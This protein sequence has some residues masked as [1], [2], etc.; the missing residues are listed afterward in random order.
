MSD[1]IMDLHFC[2]LPAPYSHYLGGVAA[3][4]HKDCER[5]YCRDCGKVWVFTFVNTGPAALGGPY[6]G[7]GYA[8][9]PERPRQRRERLG[10]EPWWIRWRPW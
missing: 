5:W 8:W 3:V 1:C 6:R 4:N 7:P 9:L 10:I 2:Q